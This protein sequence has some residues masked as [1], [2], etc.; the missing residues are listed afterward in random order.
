ML[1]FVV[2]SVIAALLL[3]PAAPALA[4]PPVSPAAPP[5]RSEAPAPAVTPATP[6][7]PTVPAASPV[8]SRMLED[9]T[10]EA[11]WTLANGLRVVTRHVPGARSAA[12]TLCYR[13]GVRED[14]PN[15][16]GL[17]ELVSQI[18]F[19]GR[20]GDVPART[21]P[22]LDQLRP[23]GW[24]M[25]VG[26]HLTE[27]TEACPT[28]LLPGM[29]HQVCQRLHGVAVGDS[30][31]RRGRADVRRRLRQNYDTQIDKTLYFLSA[32]IAAG[33]P[34]Q[35]AVR[36]ATGEGLESVTAREVGARLRER[37]VPANSVLCVVG[38]L[39]AYDMRVLIEREA[40]AI[41]SGAPAPPIVW[42]R[43][44]PGIASLGR[45]DLRKAVGVV[46]VISP[47]LTDTMHAYFTAF[48]ISVAGAGTDAWGKPDPPLTTRFQYSLTT[49]PE[50][51]RFYPPVT[52]SIGPERTLSGML[53]HLGEKIVDSTSVRLAAESVIWQAGGPLPADLLKRSLGDPT[54]I[55][56]LATTLA[57][58]EAFGDAA[59]WAAYR[60]RLGRA[61]ALG[62][63]PFFGWY[64]NPRH[65]VSL[66]LRPQ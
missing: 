24:S 46:G 25:L 66:V 9:G 7:A 45:P 34:P 56:T 4:D 21:L 20:S 51:A 48:T 14:P 54:V 10:R 59:F 49:D 12:I 43:V 64:E 29:L 40:G 65:R 17:A 58:L 47:A 37:L 60:E 41:P 23:G 35:H 22:E 38:N 44:I 31:L 13:L 18:A 63:G 52:D 61:G 27:L 3:L 16:E 32:E 8:T 19:T 15:H 6:A 50:L 2:R 1:R 5:V 55:H 33:Q 57:G 26:P 28:A 30:V 42:G 62:L 36:Y 53:D 39:D 11:R